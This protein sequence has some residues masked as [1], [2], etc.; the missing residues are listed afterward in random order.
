MIFIDWLQLNVRPQKQTFTEF[1]SFTE[2]NDHYYF[3]DQNKPT[4]VFKKLHNIYSKIDNELLAVMT[5]QPKEDFLD[6]NMIIIKFAN[7]YLYNKNFYENI[8]HFMEHCKFTFKGYTRLDLAYD[9]NKFDNGMYPEQFIQ[10]YLSGVVKKLDKVKPTV[11]SKN[12]HRLI[13]QGV[14][15]GNNSSNVSYTLYNKSDELYEKKDKPYIREIWRQNKITTGNV[16]R[17]EFR[18]SSNELLI[19]DT[20][21]AE[22]TRLG[23]MGLI[24]L[25]QE[26]I[27]QLYNCLYNKHFQFCANDGNTRVD[28]MPKLMLFDKFKNYRHI[29]INKRSNTDTSRTNKIFIKQLC[30]AS[31]WCEKYIPDYDDKRNNI[32]EIITRKIYYNDLYEWAKDKDFIPKDVF[33]EN[34]NRIMPDENILL[35]TGT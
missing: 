6:P 32:I 17:L 15:F 10:N 30:K 1:D 16:W 4:N 18:L 25:K 13:I 33:Q 27:M 28:R 3:I 35:S 20:F 34:K 22:A 8:I 11:Y 31:E 2:D 29:L 14:K 24:L 19:L 26:N 21:T 23:D 9:F 12:E 7:D 5:S